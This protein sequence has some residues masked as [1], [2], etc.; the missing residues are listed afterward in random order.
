MFCFFPAFF[1]EGSW[2]KVFR[3]GIHKPRGQLGV[4]VIQM[5]TLLHKLFL[6]KMFTK[7]LPGRG[8]KYLKICQSM[9]FMDDLISHNEHISGTILR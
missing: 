2:H 5:T 3:R 8:Q 6:V 9:W 4:G 1:Q 7:G